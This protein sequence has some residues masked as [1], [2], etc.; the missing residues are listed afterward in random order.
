MKISLRLMG[1]SIEFHR[2]DA[3]KDKEIPINEFISVNHVPLCHRDTYFKVIHGENNNLELYQQLMEKNN[4][5]YK[6]DL[7]LFAKTK[8]YHKMLKEAIMFY[9]EAKIVEAITT[10]KSLEGYYKDVY[11]HKIEYFL[12][13]QI[14]KSY[15]RRESLDHLD[16]RKL[17]YLID[18]VSSDMRVIVTHMIYFDCQRRKRMISSLRSVVRNLPFLGK[19][20]LLYKI[21]VVRQA[22]FD[23][24][25]AEALLLLKELEEECIRTENHSRLCEV[26]Q[27]YIAIYAIQNK[28]EELE[29]EKQRLYAFM[30]EYEISRYVR[31]QNEHYIGLSAF[32]EHD[33]AL[34]KTQFEKIIKE[35]KD[36]LPQFI[37]LYYFS[38]LSY[39]NQKNTLF[40]VN[41]EM[42]KEFSTHNKI[43]IRYFVLKEKGKS[44]RV[45]IDYILYKVGAII[46][47]DYIFVAN[48]FLQE[49]YLLDAGNVNINAFLEIVYK[50]NCVILQHW[51]ELFSN[52]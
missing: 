42:M 25:F 8:P 28:K 45:L 30:Q 47:R 51:Q 43:F 35:D 27:L 31:N 39:E 34:A 12:V 13:E 20:E 26:M 2:M 50:S 29:Q 10:I 11:P 40:E 14:E 21:I 48:L 5:H 3:L 36:Y 9:D 7:S 18:F 15:V 44:K 37:K 46:D 4:I 41:E 33:F 52:S 24:L 23:H 16:V 17:F 32:I 6:F 1:Y 38:I 49:L 22:I 19:D